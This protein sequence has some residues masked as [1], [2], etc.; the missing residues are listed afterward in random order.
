MTREELVQLRKDVVLQVEKLRRL[1]DHSA[2]APDI[3]ANSEAILKLV[4]H[5]LARSKPKGDD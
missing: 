2:E 5:V 3:R 4:D 1:G